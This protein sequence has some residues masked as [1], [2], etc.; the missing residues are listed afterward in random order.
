[1]GKEQYKK[2]EL[3]NEESIKALREKENYNFLSNLEV[4]TTKQIEMKIK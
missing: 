1:M 4:D 2:T 3:P